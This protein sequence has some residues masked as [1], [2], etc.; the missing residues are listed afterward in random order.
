MSQSLQQTNS[1]DKLV[2]NQS[3]LGSFKNILTKDLNKIAKKLP[4]PPILTNKKKKKEFDR[5]K[6]IKILE[7][8]HKYYAKLIYELNDLEKIENCRILLSSLNLLFLNK[9]S[10]NDDEIL[11]MYTKIKKG[12]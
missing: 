8:K 5:K 2:K 11:E 6:F 10:V 9:S 3:L 1:K 12:I 4:L 7:K